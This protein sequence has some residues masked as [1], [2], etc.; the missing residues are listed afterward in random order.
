MNLTKRLVQHILENADKFEWSLQ[1]FGM[2]RTYLHEDV[3]LH[4]WDSAFAVDEVSTVHDHPWDFTSTIIAGGLKNQRYV[5]DPEGDEWNKQ[6]IVCGPG[7]H[8]DSEVERIRLRALT[9]EH[10]IGGD[11]YF[12]SA[13]ELHESI[14]HD[15]TVTVIHRNFSRPDR[16]LATVCFPRDKQWV[17]AEPGPA[18]MRDVATIVGRSLRTWFD[19]DYKNDLG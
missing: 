16:D 3:R 11:T 10:Y 19:S 8:T 17:S 4:I 2:L 5:I 12:Q 13:E 9:P 7:G 18:H 1:G 15:G 6:M 14:P